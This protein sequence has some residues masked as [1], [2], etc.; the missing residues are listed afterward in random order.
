MIYITDI[1]YTYIYSLLSIEDQMLQ[2]DN[3]LWYSMFDHVV[4][5]IRDHIKNLLT[6]SELNKKC[7]YLC[8]V[9]GLSCSPYFQCMME[10]HFG[11]TSKYNLQI[12]KPHKPILSVIA[13]A[14]YFGITDNFIRARR[15]KHTYGVVLTLCKQQAIKRNISSQ[16]IEQNQ[17]YDKNDNKWWVKGC[18]DILVHKNQQIGLNEVI[19]RSSSRANVNVLTATGKIVSS[20][21]YDPKTINDVKILGYLTVTF[22]NKNKDNMSIVEEYHFSDTTLEVYYYTKNDPQNKRKL[23]IKYQT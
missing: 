15:L 1:L 13:G 7:K 22:N 17:Y 14:A 11:P 19:K 4:D 16:F 3:R 6:K 5:P 18:V 10:S 23:Q 20:D 12:I 8:L 9:G 21:M 2:I